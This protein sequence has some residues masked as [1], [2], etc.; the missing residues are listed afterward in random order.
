MPSKPRRRP[1]AE[2]EDDYQRRLKEWE[3]QKPHKVEKKVSGNYM[4][5]KYYT[6]RLL[7]VYIN[8][9]QQQRSFDSSSWYL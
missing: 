9:V 8:A 6:E 2:S 7:P 1:K 5:Q 4:T 3:A